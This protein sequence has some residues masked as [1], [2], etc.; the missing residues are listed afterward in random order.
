MPA[1]SAGRRSFIEPRLVGVDL[2]CGAGGLTHGLIAA[3]I[4]VVAGIDIDPACRFPFES[5]NSGVIFHQRSV[6][7]LT[8]DE[9]CEWFDGATTRVLAGCAP[10]Q[11]FSTYT[12][13]QWTR[14]SARWRLLYEFERLATEVRPEVVT[15]ENV[16]TIRRHRVFSDFV[17]ALTD[18]GYWV[19]HETVDAA[20]YGLPQR[21]R[22]IVLLASLNGPLTLGAPTHDAPRSVQDAI[23]GLPRLD[24]G[25]Y[26]LDDPL[27]I[28]PY[29]S[30]LNLAR[31][32]E[33]KPGGTW[34]DWPERLR[35]P[36]HRRRTG[37]SYDAVYGRMEWEKLAPT[38]TTQ[39]FRYGT[40]RFG[41]PDQER[42]LSLRE[43][44]LLQ[45]FPSSYQFVPDGTMPAITTAGRLIGNAVPLP[46][47]EAIGQAITAAY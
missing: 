45:G 11:P 31:I 4:P 14:D 38:L 24:S 25:E 29:L 41:H 43:G 12:N 6:E 17:K 19:H 18:A 13:G 23:G 22:R 5:N 32:R 28:A 9:L 47:A 3:G 15:M 44:A 34:R 8:A 36:C 20:D 21:R 26:C 35:A 2:F 42:A 46:L 7:D 39:F 27:H 37:A 40:G 10:C 33:S 30:P 16:P 1:A